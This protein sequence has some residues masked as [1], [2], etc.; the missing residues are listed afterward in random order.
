L[1]KIISPEEVSEEKAKAILNF[2]NNIKTDKELS[3]IVEI[4]YE[5]DVGLRVS[6]HIIDE[7]TRIGKFTKLAQIFSIKQVG[8]ERFSEIINSIEDKLSHRDIDFDL[9]EKMTIEESKSK[10]G[11]IFKNSKLVENVLKKRMEE[12]AEDFKTLEK[13]LNSD[14]EFSTAFTESP[15]K[16]LQKGG[17]IDKFDEVNIQF[18]PAITFLDPNI[19][20]RFCIKCYWVI[21][22]DCKVAWRRVVSSESYLFERNSPVKYGLELPE[23][24]CIPTIKR[25]C[26]L[27][28]KKKCITLCIKIIDGASPNISRD[29]DKANEIYSQCGIEIRVDSQETNDVPELL[30][31]DQP[32]C[33]SGQTPTDEEDELFDLMRDDCN[34]D[35]IVYYVRSTNMGVF[36]CAAF[37]AGRPGFVVTDTAT[38]FTFAH[39]LGHVLGLSH[40]TDTTNIMHGGGTNNITQD[41]PNFTENQ[42]NTIKNSSFIEEC[43]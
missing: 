28:P 21:E 25:K 40:V 6:Q 37:P 42:C 30:D 19:L 15:L 3:E 1:K 36:G 12:R 24:L 27:T 31:L 38:Q 29:I 18:A 20:L 4:P 9:V 14:D 35:I 39:E 33:F 41:P 32:S 11:K 10:I 34:S 23:V 2:I 16:I 43:C 8:R 7:R 17:F 26:V 22:L 5:R 13:R